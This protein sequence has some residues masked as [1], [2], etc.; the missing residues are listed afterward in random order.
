MTSLNWL[1]HA[2]NHVDRWSTRVS[3]V[4]FALSIYV[5]MPALIILVTLDVV[6]RYIFNAPLQW[7]RDANGLLLMMTIF[8]ALPHAWD[9]AYHI[10]MEVFYL[11]LSE[12]RR[13]AVDLTVQRPLVPTDHVPLAL[14]LVPS[15]GEPHEPLSEATVFGFSPEGRIARHDPHRAARLESELPRNPRERL[16]LL[17]VKGDVSDEIRFAESP[18]NVLIED[19]HVII[20]GI[21]DAVQVAS[22]KSTS[23]G[24]KSRFEFLS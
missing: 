12:T 6:L 8:F 20:H 24:F 16:P 2:A 22:I 21:I 3:S 14:A 23:P 11:R 18:R 15:L 1:D 5:T 10:R 9:R 17:R 7:G 4:L 13:R 19:H